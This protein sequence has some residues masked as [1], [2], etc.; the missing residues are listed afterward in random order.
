MKWH[1]DNGLD[2]LFIKRENISLKRHSW[3][4]GWEAI[5]SCFLCSHS[6]HNRRNK[7][8][9]EDLYELSSLYLSYICMSFLDLFRRIKFIYI[10]MFS[11]MKS[12]TFLGEKRER[13]S[14]FFFILTVWKTMV[15]CTET[16]FINS[17]LRRQAK[18]D[19]HLLFRV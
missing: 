19:H 8:H 9:Q 16:P 14:H 7:L 2:V 1:K 6:C 11:L 10:P 18:G 17:S 12:K 5:L 15:R 3:I 4:R 13:E